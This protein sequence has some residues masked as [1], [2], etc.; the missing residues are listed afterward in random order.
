MYVLVHSAIGARNSRQ[1][2]AFS[3]L[4]FKCISKIE[5]PYK[6]DVCDRCQELEASCCVFFVIFLKYIFKIEFPYKIDVC[7]TY[8]YICISF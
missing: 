5:F 3:S 4:F 2:V 6:I 8:I 1:V 7:S